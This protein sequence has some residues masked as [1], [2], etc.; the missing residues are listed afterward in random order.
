MLNL[1]TGYAANPA[2][3]VYRMLNLKTNKVLIN[4][5]VRW[6][7]TLETGDKKTKQDI[8]H[9]VNIDYQDFKRIEKELES[10][11][12]ASEENEHDV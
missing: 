9:N 1:K 7:N 3:N 8:Y 5:D 12:Q 4:R 10:P 6:L 11:L 2:G